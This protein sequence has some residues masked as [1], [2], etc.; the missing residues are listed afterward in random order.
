[1]SNSKLYDKSFKVPNNILKHIK[2]V[3][4]SNPSG[5][6]VKRAK[7]IVKNESL[8]YSAL[9][10]LKNFFDYF[11]HQKDSKVQYELAGGDLM[12][13]FV[14]QTLNSERSAV[15]REEKIKSLNNDARNDVKLTTKAY[16]TPRLNESEVNKNSI[17]II[18]N[19]DNE[20]L[21]V[22]RSGYENQWM[23]NKW[24]LVGGKVNKDETPERA[25]VRE[26]EE[27]VGLKIT[28]LLKRFVIQRDVNSVEYIFAVRYQD[29]PDN[30]TLNPENSDYVWLTYDEIEVLDDK[31]PNLLD[32][33]NMA[34]KKY[35]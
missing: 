5:D 1:M 18:V 25:C 16:R 28:K 22:R 4:V 10:R 30:V 32:Y 2:S 20:F 9:K 7:H 17:C 31:V 3:L 19:K 15:D 33:I 12:K 13:I 8:T 34:F 24:S 6:G 35:E 29:D 11:N 21:L 27:E 26:V 14:E 23:P